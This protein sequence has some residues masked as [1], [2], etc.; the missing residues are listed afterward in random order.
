MP[1]M[2][3]TVKA[4]KEAG[5]PAKVVVGG[6]PVSTDFADQIGAEGFSDSAPGAVELTRSLMAT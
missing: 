2:A 3:D 1:A 6:A 5:S 4:F